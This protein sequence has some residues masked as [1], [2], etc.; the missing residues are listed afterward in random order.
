[1]HAVVLFLVLAFEE[2]ETFARYVCISRLAPPLF[3]VSLK[4]VQQWDI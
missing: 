3:C 2:K 1:M 4:G